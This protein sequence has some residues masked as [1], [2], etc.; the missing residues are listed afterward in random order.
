MIEGHGSLKSDVDE[1]LLITIP[2]KSAVR[3]HNIKI[4]GPEGNPA[5]AF[6]SITFQQ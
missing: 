1:E 5:F 3:L 6:L 2:F 4:E